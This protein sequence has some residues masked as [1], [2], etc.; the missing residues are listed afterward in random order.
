MSWKKTLILG[1]IFLCAG[2]G[3]FLDRGLT[4]KRQLTRE[5]E[6][7]LFTLKKEDITAF[8]LTNPEGSFRLEKKDEK[9]RIA[10]HG[11]LKAD[12]DQVESLLANLAGAKRYDPVETKDLEQYGLDKPLE[13]VILECEKTGGKQTLYIGLESATS[14]RYF[15]TAVGDKTV[16][17]VAS[18]IRNFLDKNLF[19]LRDKTVFD[20][21]AGDMVKIEIA[22]DEQK[23]VLE[24]SGEAEW[25]LLSPV[26]DK[27]DITAVRNLLTDIETLRAASFEEDALTTPGSF[28]L[29]AP[30]IH[31]TIGSSETTPTLV[32]GKEDP[33]AP[34]F[35]AQKGD[36]GQIFTVSK[37]FV[38]ELQKDA[39]QF[40]SREVFRIPADD[41]QEIK[42]IVGEGVVSLVREE[43]DK[44][45]F[46]EAPDI[47]VHQG[48]AQDLLREIGGLQIKSFEDESP[49]SLEPY[50]LSAPR[51]RLIL[52]PGDRDKKEI[53]SFGNKAE[54]RDICFARIS[55]RPLIFGLD[56]T[57]VCNFY[58][59]RHDLEDRRLFSI[60]TEDVYRIEIGEAA[61]KR[62]LEKKGERWFAR[63]ES[64]V[65][66][67]EIPSYSVLGVITD[68]GELEFDA[69]L[70]EEKIKAIQDISP[71]KILEGVLKDKDGKILES[72]E[73]FG[74]DA[75][76]S[77]TLKTATGGY[78][79]IAKEK[80][81]KFRAD[82]DALF[83]NH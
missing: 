41:I 46:Q 33:G 35:F 51:A 65:K 42:I 24:K 54:G 74:S 7:A 20:I 66:G 79:L 78:F 62:Y 3:Y 30:L 37:R 67:T 36:A 64:E 44:W 76:P 47:S 6:E 70:D 11:D 14:G 18:H 60:S 13:T 72:L 48:K 59:T 10:N 50:G 58:L 1:L 63:T 27:A 80:M 4:Q 19:Y 43:G 32:I 2:A 8:T 25:R 31:L 5:R 56:W 49:A 15:A 77:L 21:K 73:V 75:E 45:N 69:R 81:E 12:A 39:G 71:E 16:F 55:H 61:Q 53:L 26:K 22:R 83:E 17:T 52:Y 9:W 68:I 40:R 38:E 23:V 57:K 82:F 29:D 28:G 34:R